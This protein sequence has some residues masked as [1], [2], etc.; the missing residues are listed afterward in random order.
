MCRSET[1]GPSGSL[2][3]SLNRRIT[4]RVNVLCAK[5]LTTP[6]SPELYEVLR[7]LRT[8]M[9]EHTRRLRTMAANMAVA[10]RRNVNRTQ[11][12]D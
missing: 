9:R 6:D 7:L 2:C 3:L 11:A 5:A 8:A 12:A 10:D 4:D 1:I